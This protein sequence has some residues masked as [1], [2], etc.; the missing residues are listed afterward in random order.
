MSGEVLGAGVD[1]Y[2]DID[3]VQIVDA[4]LYGDQLFSRSTTEVD[5]E[6]DCSSCWEWKERRQQAEDEKLRTTAVGKI[7]I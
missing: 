1:F 4:A 7:E 3:S 2:A 5:A 6:P